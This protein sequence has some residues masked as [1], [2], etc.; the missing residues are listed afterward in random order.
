[1]VTETESTDSA[2]AVSRVG[3]DGLAIKP[4]ECS[5]REV[6]RT[7]LEAVETVTVDYEGARHV[8]GP[9]TLCELGRHVDVRVTVPVR[10]DGFDPLGVDEAARSLPE[11]VGRVLVAGH[12]TY[13]ETAERKRAVAPRLGAAL[14]R[15]PNAWVGTEGLERLA[16]ATGAT[17]FDLLTGRSERELRG[18]RAAGYDGR[19][20][21]YAPTVLTDDEDAILDAVGAYVARRHPVSRTLPADATTD[22]SV[23]GQA[24]ETLLDAAREYAL[25]GDIETVSSRIEALREAGASTVVGYPARGLETIASVGR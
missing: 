8:P 21:V 15:W 14:E 25:A 16:M 17:Q 10:A 9:D 3:L 4:S 11:A 1:M 5:L 2:H 22:A 24:R 18:L 19:I 20:A 12:P 23:T 6:P 13:L 7:L